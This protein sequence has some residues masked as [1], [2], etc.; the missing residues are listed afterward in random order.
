[1]ILKPCR[2]GADGAVMVLKPGVEMRPGDAL[3]MMLAADG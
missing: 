2:V 3:L 1:M